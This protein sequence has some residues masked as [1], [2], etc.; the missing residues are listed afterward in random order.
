M[1]LACTFGFF[2]QLPEVLMDLVQYH[3]DRLIQKGLL[4]LDQYYSFYGDLF[5]IALSIQLLLTT[6][7]LEVYDHIKNMQDQ[8]DQFLSAGYTDE[9]IPAAKS[10][11]TSLTRLC[12]I[13]GEVDEPNP[14]NQKIIM[15]FGRFCS[16]CWKNNN[17]YCLKI[18][19]R[20]CFKHFELYYRMERCIFDS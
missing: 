17:L 6:E 2:S 9:Y 14:I 12:Y 16:D 4:V 19:C 8:L 7:S 3:S 5:D 15:N 18:F 1:E 13:E 20:N 11:L 10:A